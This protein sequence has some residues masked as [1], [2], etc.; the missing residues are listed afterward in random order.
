MKKLLTLGLFLF[1][2]I[3]AIGQINYEKGY[4]IK[5][6]GDKVEAF[7]R[8]SNS[9]QKEGKFNFKLTEKGIVNSISA[10]EVQELGIGDDT[11]FL[12][13]IIQ[14]D[15]SSS[16]Q[17][18]L[19]ENKDPDYKESREFIQVLIEGTANLYFYKFKNNQYY[20]STQ[21]DR[22]IKPLVNKKYLVDDSKIEENNLY[23]RQLF[24]HLKCNFEKSPVFQE[25]DYKRDDLIDFFRRYNE[26]K[27][28]DYKDYSKRDNKFEVNLNLRPG[29][30]QST[31][32]LVFGD[33][34]GSKREFSKVS[35]IGFR[36]GVE[37]EF[38]LPF[39]RNKWAFTVEPAYQYF[40]YEEVR[41]DQEVRVDFSSVEVP[42]GL[43][44]YLFLNEDSK[45]FINAA[46]VPIFNIKSDVYL[47]HYDDIGLA[48]KPYFSGGIGFKYKNKYSAEFRVGSKRDIIVNRETRWH[49]DFQTISFI[50]GYSIF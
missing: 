9:I 21:E 45:I 42:I 23:R 5:E 20:Y 38:V 8:N 36:L 1:S 4:F 37:G 30:N 29:I 16:I 35:E 22:D 31:F 43:R 11:K 32:Q 17:R 15:Q 13:R 46:F 2:G 6:S 27:D 19:D 50:V 34:R 25:I 47:Q 48:D 33:R 44:H 28:E 18:S 49:S 14:I 41:Y 24:D 39:N 12:S 40:S 7:I 3:M 26:C 10:S